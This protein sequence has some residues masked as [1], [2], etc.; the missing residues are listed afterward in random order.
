MKRMYQS[1][2]T[3]IG[4]YTRTLVLIGGGH[5]HALLLRAIGLK[6][7]SGLRVVLIT[8]VS[9]APY[10]GMLPGLIAGHYRQQEIHIDLTELSIFAGAEI[11]LDKAVAIDRDKKL[12][13]LDKH[14]PVSYD[15]LSINIGSTPSISAVKGADQFATPAKP[16]A[17]LL[18]VIQ[19]ISASAGDLKQVKITV[20]GAGAGGIEIALSLRSRFGKLTKITLL[21]QGNEVLKG[22]GTRA[23]HLAIAALLRADIQLLLCQRIR[24]VRAREVVFD[25]LSS[26]ESDHTIWVTSASA[27]KWLEDSGLSVNGDGFI[28]VDNSL[29]SIS[30]QDIFAAGDIAALEGQQI[31]KSGVFAVKQAAPLYH[32]ILRRLLNKPLLTYSPQKRH[33]A[34][35]GLGEKRAIA[36]WGR[37]AFES[38]LIW[39]IKEWID[40]RFMRKFQRLSRI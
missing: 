24:E 9:Q 29:C 12:V 5:A 23:R 22:H 25:D 2:K 11:V 33:L 28:R 27:P 32:N 13:K 39:S 36:S 40:R 6:P 14:A 30:D 4:N 19:R 21:E 16:V 34:I 1:S 26:L 17:A 15:L 31:P 8:D 20:V 38:C 37:F 3:G 10:S 18:K 35:I 7:V